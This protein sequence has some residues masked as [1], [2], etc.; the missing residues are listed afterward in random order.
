[1][2]TSERQREL[3][4]LT[5]RLEDIAETVQELGNECVFSTRTVLHHAALEV[6]GEVARLRHE[7]IMNGDVAGQSAVPGRL[8]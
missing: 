6:F 4:E 8:L 7:L 2:T 1:M 5:H 3:W